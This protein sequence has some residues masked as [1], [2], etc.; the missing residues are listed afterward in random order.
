[1]INNVVYI[2]GFDLPDKN[3]A[4]I[5]VTNI[6]R[7][8]EN[9]GYNP[10]FLSY[11]N[12]KVID[13][14]YKIIY[15]DVNNYYI[16]SFKKIIK[17]IEQIENIKYIVTYNLPS[18]LLLKLIKYSKKN[19]IRILGD[20][21][22]WYGSQGNNLF[23]KALKGIDSFVRMRI[24][25]KKMDGIIAISKFLYNY[26]SK[27]TNTVLIPPLYDIC[28]IVKTENVITN[29]IKLI[30]AGQVGRKKER[31]DKIIDAIKKVNDLG[32]LKI[33][34][35]IYGI[36]K[37][38]YEKIYNT[39]FDDNFVKF[40]GK[41]SNSVCKEA[42]LNSNFSIIIRDNN[43]VT[44]AGFPTKFVESISLGVPVISNAYSNVSDY[45]NDNGILI[46]MNSLANELNERLLEIQGKNFVAKND[47]FLYKNY[48]NQFN[49]FLKEIGSNDD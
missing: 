13:Y 43:R 33:E 40:Y 30:Y 41:V 48:I 17:Q 11:K 19:Q 3:A 44:M 21:T 47:T 29:K 32:K 49:E 27:Y 8:F 31:V 10:I 46:D 1:M 36:S 4:G 20:I 9:I 28:E 2:G 34:L 16:C 39:K 12:K 22:E 5:R 37:E 14:K 15:V 42:I 35:N 38:S 18:L 23:Q 24:L 7:I 45:I 25:N 26:Y 6:G